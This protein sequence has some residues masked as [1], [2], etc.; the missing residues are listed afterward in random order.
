MHLNVCP[1]WAYIYSQFVMHLLF[2]C[3]LMEA[4]DQLQRW[5]QKEGWTELK[6]E[7]QQNVI[8]DIPPAL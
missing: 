8:L 2:A 4:L 5:P 3:W 7:R 1:N 6:R